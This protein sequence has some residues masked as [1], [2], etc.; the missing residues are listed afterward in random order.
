M[1]EVTGVRVRFS[2][3]GRL[4]AVDVGASNEVNDRRWSLAG[5]GPGAAGGGQGTSS[6]AS[7]SSEPD[8]VESKGTLGS[9]W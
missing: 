1:G 7:P 8:P 5:S 3:Q 9:A 6:D 2:G 4:Q